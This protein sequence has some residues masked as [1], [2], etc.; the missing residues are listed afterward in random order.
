VEPKRALIDNQGAQTGDQTSRD[1]AGRDI[2]QGADANSVLDFLRSYVFE[3]DQRRETA[4]KELNRE[5]RLSRDD[6]VII[7][8]ALRTVRDRVD[9]LIV[10]RDVDKL[11]REDRQGVLDEAL[12]ALRDEQERLR[13]LV[14][15]CSARNRRAL[16]WITIG[17]IVALLIAGWVAYDR[18]SAFAMV[19]VWTGGGAAL[20]WAFLRGR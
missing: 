13:L 17:L 4:L 18:Y 5:I 7:G 1:L 11:D 12:K 6:M 20:A 15:A 8:D 2:H 10:D 14:E 16:I 3:A 9:D 19:R